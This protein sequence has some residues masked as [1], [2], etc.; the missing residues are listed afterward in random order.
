VD[1]AH[2]ILGSLRYFLGAATHHRDRDGSKMDFGQAFGVA[3]NGRG[4]SKLLPSSS[5]D[6][7]EAIHLAPYSFTGPGA[8]LQ[9]PRTADF[10]YREPANREYDH[11]AHG[12]LP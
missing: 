8:Q 3:P 1:F 2:E 11:H 6:E 9:S 4:N 5:A 10:E 7:G 12:R